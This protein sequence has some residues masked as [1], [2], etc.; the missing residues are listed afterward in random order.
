MTFDQATYDVRFE[1]GERGVTTLGPVS[2]VLIIVDVMSFST[3]VTVA[4]ARGATVYPYQWRDDSSAG[5][6][7]SIGAELAGPRGSTGYSLSPASLVGIPAGTRLVLPSPNG[8]SLTL[9]AGDTAVWAGCLR[10]AQAVAD[11]AARVN[12]PIAVIGAGE[13]WKDDGSLRPAYEDLI[14]AGAIISHL[15][16]WRSPEAQ[17]TVDAFEAARPTLLTRLCDCLSGREL[18]ELG[19]ESDVQIISELDA[20]SCVPVMSCGAYR[21]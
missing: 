4:A 3:C 12:G 11:A 17:M 18:I 10:N 21:A 8:S 2:A 20:D 6:A 1:W 16:G 7:R 14:G 13:R 15:P 9:L 19:F 5:F